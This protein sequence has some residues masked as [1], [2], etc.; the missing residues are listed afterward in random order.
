MKIIRKITSLILLAGISTLPVL[1]HHSHSTIDRND[2]RV[3]RGIVTTFGWSMPH[4]YLK[5]NA[6]NLQGEIVEFSIEMNHP[7]AMTERGWSKDSFKVGDVVTWEGAHHRNKAR[8]YSSMSW[9]ENDGVRIGNSNQDQVPILP[10]TDL[11]GLWDR[12][13]NQPTYSPPGHPGN[14]LSEVWPLT[15]MGEALIANFNEDQNPVLTCGDPGPPKSMTLPYSHQISRVDENTL[16]IGRDLMEGQRVV[17]LDGR[18]ASSPPSKLGHSIGWFEGADL[19]VETSNFTA[20]VWG[21]HTGIDS[22]DQKHLIERFNLS[23][24]G[25]AIELTITLTDPVYLAKPVTF[26][27]QWIKTIDRELVQTPCTMESAQ[28]W[29]EAGYN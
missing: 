12:A 2:V 6:P 11:T 15:E 25:L 19:I 21:A 9:I 3:L 14:F 18:S 28:L 26:T 23:D 16:I 8:A 17:H 27:H 29:I 20:D 22:S 5:V 13:P 7:A 1:A 4:V 24:D 10:S